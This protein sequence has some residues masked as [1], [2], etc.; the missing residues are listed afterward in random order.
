MPALAAA[1]VAAR[2]ALARLRLLAAAAAARL[3]PLAPR[4]A[5]ADAAADKNKMCEGSVH[6]G[7]RMVDGGVNSPATA[8][9]SSFR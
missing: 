7:A 8:T 9:P 1:A 4:D 2:V 5:R 3:R 6:K